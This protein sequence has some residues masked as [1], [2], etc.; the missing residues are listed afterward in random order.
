MNHLN[1]KRHELLCAMLRAGVSPQMSSKAT[2]TPL[3]QAKSL[4][5]QLQLELAA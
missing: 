5:R 3:Y 4:A 1:T 2:Q